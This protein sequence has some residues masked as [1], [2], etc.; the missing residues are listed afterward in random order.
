MADFVITNTGKHTLNATGKRTEIFTHSYRHAANASKAYTIENANPYAIDCMLSAQAGSGD[1]DTYQWRAHESTQYERA[2]RRGN[3]VQILLNGR[4][5]F[6]LSGG[7]GNPQSQTGDWSWRGDSKGWVKNWS[8]NPLRCMQ[9]GESLIAL[10]TLPPRSVLTISYL[11]Q[12][13][14]NAAFKGSHTLSGVK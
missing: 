5:L 4:A 9:S 12:N 14:A 8:R 13:A 6:Y 7:A 1:Y 2:G 10:I 11:Y 3:N